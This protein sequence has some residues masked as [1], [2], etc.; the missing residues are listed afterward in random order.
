MSNVFFTSDT[1]FGHTNIIKYCNRPFSS[2]AEMDAELIK[3]WNSKVAEG[4]VVM[5][6]GDFCFGNAKKYRDQLNGE[7]RMIR[8]NHDRDAEYLYSLKNERSFLS[9]EDVRT[10]VYKNQGIW[11]SHYAHRVWPKSHRGHWHLYGH[12]HGTLPDDP[13]SLSFD[14]GVD[15]HNF[16]P[17]S[18]DEVKELMSKKTFKPVDHHGSS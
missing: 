10:V 5:H 1:H 6:L 17:L 13:N 16:Y 4:D 11:L 15:C 7:I 2:V 8:G 18:F 3:R 9:F 14:C 12:S